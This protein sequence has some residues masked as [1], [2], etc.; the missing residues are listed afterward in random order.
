MTA[1]IATFVLVW[2]VH[3]FGVIHSAPGYENEQTC[4]KAARTLESSGMA[5]RAQ[6]IPGPEQQTDDEIDRQH[7]KPCDK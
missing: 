6:C 5:Q 7:C 1:V 3:S 2:Q 4:Q